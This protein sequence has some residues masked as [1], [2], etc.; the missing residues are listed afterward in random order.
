MKVTNWRRKLMASLVAG[1]V[2]AP[3]AANAAN[4]GVNLLANPGFESV[5]PGT[6]G[7]YNAPKILNWLGTNPAFA[8]SHNPGV[9][10]IPDYADGADPPGAGSWY[11]SSNNNPA[12]ATGDFRNPNE[13]FQDLDVSTGPTG[14]QIATGEAAFKLSAYMSSYLNDSDNGNVQLDFKNGGG[15]ILGSAIISDPD[16]G[17]NNVWSLTSKVGLVPVG[18]ATIRASIFG[19]PRNGGAD[20]YIDNVD[21]QVAT[22]PSVMLILEVNTNTGQMTLKNQTGAAVNI[23]YYEVTSATGALN[24]TGWN[25]FQEQNLAGF[26]AGNGSGNGWEQFGGSSSNVIGESY[27]TSSS[28]VA[29]NA[30]MNLGSGFNVGGAH[31]LVFQ[32]GAFTNVTANPTGD[33]NNDGTVNAA[34]YVLW[35]DGGTLFN[36]PSPGVQPSDYDQWKANFGTSGGLVGPS[37]L[38]PGFV[39]YVT[40]GV[41]SGAAVPEPTSVFLAGV[42]LAVMSI[43][44]RRRTAED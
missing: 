20:G 9:T 22:V 4:L 15:T 34:D 10:G 1:G 19:T 33:Y 8:Y 27:L 36:D 28:A 42:G 21:V 2:M 13:V 40:S 17:P 16:F 38:T 32:Y 18:T 30:S 44:A 12:G 39:R 25:S 11:F 29:N 7:V 6:V 14:T 24:S 3:A 41:G 26:P 43:T 23:D 31:N 37:T 35:R 5:D